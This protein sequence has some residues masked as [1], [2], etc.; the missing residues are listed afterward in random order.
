MHE[1]TPA[2]NIYT[3]LGDLDFRDPTKLDERGGKLPK[4]AFGLKPN[5]RTSNME[6]PGPGEYNTD[7]H[8]MN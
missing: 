5:I 3:I 2:P 7:K 1:A 6:T 8:P 4:F